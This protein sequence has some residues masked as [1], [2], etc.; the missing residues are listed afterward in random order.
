LALRLFVALNW[1]ANIQRFFIDPMRPVRLEMTTLSITIEGEASTAALS[2]A[3]LVA[4]I[5]ALGDADKLAL[6][7]IA[8]LYA[9]RTP[10]DHDDLLQEAICRVLSGKRVWTRGVPVRSFLV[11]VM[12]SIAWEWKSEPH[13]AVVDAPNPEC[14]ESPIMA[15]IDSAK[16]VAMFANDLV[17]QKIVLGMM[18]GARGEELQRSSGLSQVEYESKRKKIRRRIEKL[19]GE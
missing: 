5:Q 18:E 2:Q 14:G 17:A 8:R 15:S 4:I 7:K 16:I 11:G 3:E 1:S 12:R 19:G 10:F 6:I 13:E 9:R